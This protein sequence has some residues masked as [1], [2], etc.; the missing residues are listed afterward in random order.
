MD[1]D[2][3]EVAVA[4]PVRQTFLTDRAV[5]RQIENVAKDSL[6]DGV[7]GRVVARGMPDGNVA[8]VEPGHFI[9]EPVPP[10]GAQLRFAGG[11]SNNLVARKDDE[12]RVRCEPSHDG[13]DGG[14]ML[15][16]RCSRNP[17]AGITIDDE[18][19]TFPARKYRWYRKHWRTLGYLGH[20]LSLFLPATKNLSALDACMSP[21]PQQLSGPLSHP[22]T[23]GEPGQRS[24]ERSTP[25]R[26][27]S[28]PRRC[29]WAEHRLGGGPRIGEPCR[30][31]RAC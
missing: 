25:T 15:F 8:S 20:W 30:Q 17:G 2:H 29:S 18:L 6:A 16:M 22:A 5:A 3:Q 7:I 23:R 12:L 10:L 11:Q 1:E 28:S 4:Y 26:Q 24:S 13:V 19:V 31:P 21:R 27:A 14:K 9:G